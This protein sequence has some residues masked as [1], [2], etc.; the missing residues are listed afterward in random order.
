M[1]P[2]TPANIVFNLLLE[3]LGRVRGGILLL[4][5]AGVLHP[6][7]ECR[8]RDVHPREHAHGAIFRQSPAHADF[9]QERQRVD[10]DV[11]GDAVGRRAETSRAGGHFLFLAAIL[12]VGGTPT[13]AF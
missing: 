13:L 6:A 1:G 8:A 7:G 9:R 12:V 4:A 5:G 2:Q 11:G 10:L 3:S